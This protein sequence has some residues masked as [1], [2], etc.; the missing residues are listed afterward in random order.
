MGLLDALAKKNII[1]RKAVS[2]IEDEV[3]SSGKTVEAI[4]GERGVDPLK[5]LETKG[6]LL[7]VPTRTVG[8]QI[9]FE[10]LSHI[11]EDSAK[12][13]KMV[14]LALVDGALEVGMVDPDNIEALDALNFISSR[15][16]LPYKIFLISETDFQDII[17][18]YKE[19]ITGEVSEAVSQYTYAAE[20]E[21]QLQKEKEQ[22]KSN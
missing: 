12:H 4:L 11:A 22:K 2:A 17:Q 15:V 16:G 14:A 13:Y 10:I 5:I 19:D 18:M 8:E 20:Q 6:E 9:P 7:N 1:E 3:A 21:Q